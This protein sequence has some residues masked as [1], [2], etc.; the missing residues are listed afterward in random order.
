LA[1]SYADIAYENRSIDEEIDSVLESSDSGSDALAALKAKLSGG[2][3]PKA[4]E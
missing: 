4:I 3:E 2:D 1:E